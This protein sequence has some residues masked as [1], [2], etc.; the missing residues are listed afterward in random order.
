[1]ITL[2]PGGEPIPG[3]FL[4]EKLGAGSFGV[5]W[6]ADGP[7]QTRVALKFLDLDHAGGLK[8]F[9][10]IS[11]IKNIRHPNLLPI[12]GF[13]LLDRSGKPIRDGRSSRFRMSSNEPATL[14]IAMVA[15]DKSLD[16]VL[17][18][19]Q[20]H[21]RSGIPLPELLDYLEDAARG[22][23]YLNAPRHDLGDGRPVSIQHRDI[24][25]D[26]IL[27]VGDAAVLCDFGVARPCYAE[28][29][30]T[31]GMI[32]SPAFISPESI[33]GNV[34]GGASDQYSLALTYYYLRTGQHAVQVLNHATAINCHMTGRLD[35]TRVDNAERIVLQKATSLEATS[36]FDSCRDM[37]RALQ[38]CVAQS[39]G[40]ITSSASV[41]QAAADVTATAVDPRFQ[42][43][44]AADSTNSRREVCSARGPVAATPT[45]ERCQESTS[46]SAGKESWRRT[47]CGS[48]RLVRWS[49]APIALIALAVLVL[50]LAPHP[51]VVRAD[52]HAAPTNTSDK[53]VQHQSDSEMIPG[54]EVAPT[55]PAPVTPIEPAEI[56]ITSD[57]NSPSVT[58]SSEVT[59]VVQ[60]ELPATTPADKPP[61]GKTVEV[62]KDVEIVSDSKANSVADVELPVEMIEPPVLSDAERAVASFRKLGGVFSQD[63]TELDLSGSKVTNAELRQ[64]QF[65][66]EL[67]S[68]CLEETGIGNEG[69][70]IIGE[71]QPNLSSLF[72][73]RTKV[74]DVGLRHL[75]KLV[76]LVSIDLA[77]CDIHDSGLVYFRGLEN[78]KAVGLRSTGVSG[79]GVHSLSDALMHRAVIQGPEFNLL[80]GKR[81]DVTE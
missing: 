53:E 50:Q 35:F 18:D 77:S 81:F 43:T 2:Q 59:D 37:V 1:M 63:L 31:T 65:L 70:E 51:Q 40:T 15:G 39:D 66:P 7:G 46:G 23:D 80:G 8:E 25:P 12:T 16:D 71:C 69:L 20:S 58:E 47:K 38:R 61:V 42:S 48:A 45:S 62:A 34:S 4:A 14:V 13:W 68:L 28:S 60:S 30:R 67:R 5:V 64:L 21:G 41:A 79:D 3:Y 54:V 72:L 26:N 57:T 24:K 22:L 78:L 33:N 76:E 56:A 55:I 36:R 29:A 74:S 75:A 11:A 17:R 73:S 52:R 27:L 49:L 9:E 6:S 10:A 44:T 19:H 32:G